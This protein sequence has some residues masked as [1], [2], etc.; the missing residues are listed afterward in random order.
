MPRGNG[1]STLLSG[2]GLYCLCADGEPGAEVY[3]FATTR[4]QAGI[5]FGLEV[6]AHSLY[7]PKTGS[8][9]QAK[10]AEG[11]TLDGLNTHLAIVDELHPPQDPSGL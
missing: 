4:D 5:V 1:K 8:A 3:S 7:V 10:S 9:F 2:I 6:L 11:S